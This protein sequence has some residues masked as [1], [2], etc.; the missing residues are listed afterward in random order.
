MTCT[1]KKYY[2]LVWNF[3]K[4][5]PVVRSTLLAEAHALNGGYTTYTNLHR[6]ISSNVLY[7]LIFKNNATQTQIQACLIKIIKSNTHTYFL[8]WLKT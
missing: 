5:K 2:P 1:G 4:V 8:D 3:N 7:K 6:L